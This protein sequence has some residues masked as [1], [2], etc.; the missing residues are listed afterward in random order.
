MIVKQIVVW[1]ENKQARANP[2]RRYEHWDDFYF[3]QRIITTMIASLFFTAL[4]SVFVTVV[5]SWMVV[6]MY[7]ALAAYED[8]K[9]QVDLRLLWPPGNSRWSAVSHVVFIV[10]GFIVNELKNVIGHGS[11]NLVFQTIVPPAIGGLAT[12]T[13]MCILG[14][15]LF[16]L[17]SYRQAIFAGRRGKFGFDPASVNVGNASKYI[18]YQT[19]HCV[20]GYFGILL[21]LFVIALAIVLLIFVKPLFPALR[22]AIEQNI[23]TTLAVLFPLIIQQVVKLLLVNR[24][25]EIRN[26]LLFA[27]ADYSFMVGAVITFC[28][29]IVLTLVDGCRWS[30]SSLEAW[31]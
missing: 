27:V 30:I 12:I 2:F 8:L 9:D 29:H 1:Y 17:N 14:T 4:V 6:Y 5:F 26:M 22:A 11:F 3:S 24:R 25:G 16:I 28:C 31:L 19:V 20:I 13:W 23:P 15:W 10:F 18:G 7:D 21:F